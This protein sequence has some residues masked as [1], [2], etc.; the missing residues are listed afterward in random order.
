MR[1]G[2]FSGA[3]GQEARRDALSLRKSLP[4]SDPAH[5]GH[6]SLCSMWLH[7]GTFEHH[8]PAWQEL[9]Y[10]LRGETEG[11]CHSMQMSKELNTLFIILEKKNK[12]YDCHKTG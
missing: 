1:E 2:P 12:I 7:L 8:N 6:D 11:L 10:W 4:S 3:K 5:H 9:H